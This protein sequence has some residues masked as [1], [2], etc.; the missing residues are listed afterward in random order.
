MECIEGKAWVFGNGI[1]TDVMAPG[2]YFSHYAAVY[3]HELTEQAPNVIYLNTEQSP[4]Y[5]GENS[6]TQ[7]GIDAAFKRP[8]RVS[9]NIASFRESGF[10]RIHLNACW[11]IPA[12]HKPQK[13]IP[14]A[15]TP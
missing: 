3:L 5:Q 4:K 6:L 2:S 8:R 13:D 14:N 7:A 9:K 11:S 15:A 1:N 12:F 10:R